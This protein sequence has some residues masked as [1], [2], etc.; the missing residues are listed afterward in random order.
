MI[1]KINFLIIILGILLPACFKP[2]VAPPLEFNG[3]ANMT[4]AELHLLRTLSAKPATFI[5]TDIIITG[6]VTSTDQ[7]GSSYRELFFQ[8]ETGG[9]SIRIANTSYH[10]RYRI[11]Q[12]IFVSV[13]GL[14][15]GN[16][17]NNA[18][19]AF[20]FYQLGLWGNGGMINLPN[21]VEIRHIFRSGV[22]GAPPAPKIITK[23]SDIEEG[24][25]HTLVKLVNCYFIEAN[26]ETKYYEERLV[27]GGAANQIIRFNLG[28]GEVA[29]RISSYNTF[30]NNILPSGALNITGLLTKF[31]NTSQLIIRSIDDVEV[32]P[33]VKILRSFDMTTDPFLQGWENRQIAGTDTWT[34]YTANNHVRV[35]PPSGN[36][37]ECWFVSPKFNFTGEKDIALS[38]NYRLTA[39]TSEN[40]QLRYTID[41]TNWEQL[42]FTPQTGTTETTIRLNDNIATNPNF[43]IAF[44]YK[45]TTIFPMCAIMNI[46]FKANVVM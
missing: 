2:E 27:L 43:Q 42:D 12:R 39:G 8:D 1:K 14:Y 5:D 31:G 40:L 30:A 3:E 36:E 6:I 41:G 23:Q 45:T 15:L 11:G 13:K 21:N 19:T 33:P 25:Y 34:Y 38:F 32:L 26:G 18:G 9:I 24:D 44:Q 17:T 7:F 28:A 29:A 35:Q 20:G 10:T 16:Y 4:I 46:T 37:T 22:P